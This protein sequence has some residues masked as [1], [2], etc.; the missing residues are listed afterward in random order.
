MDKNK[1]T[2]IHNIPNKMLL[3]CADIVAP[4]LTDIF[5]YFLVSKIFLDDFKIGKVSPLFKNGERDRILIT[6]DI[7]QSCPR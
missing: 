6:I 5:N 1:A 2:G 7:F 4:N 3:L